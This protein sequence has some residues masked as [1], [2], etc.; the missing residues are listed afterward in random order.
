MLELAFPQP[1]PLLSLNDRDHWSIRAKG[2]RTWRQAAWAAAHQWRQRGQVRDYLEAGIV[3]VR[4]PVKDRR[5]RDPHNFTPTL[6]AIVDGLVDA[7][8]WPDDHAGHLTTTEPQLWIP[9][10][11]EDPR[12]KVWVVAR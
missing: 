12:V 10:P 1:A 4:L 7:K 5:R 9:Q 2:V 11:G 3:T 6:K 8:L